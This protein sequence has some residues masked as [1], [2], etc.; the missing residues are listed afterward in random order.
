MK[1]K[2]IGLAIC[3][4]FAFNV[5]QVSAQADLPEAEIIE[6]DTIQKKVEVAFRSVD[7]MD[8]LGGVSVID[9][10]AMTK[11]AYTSSSF[12]FIENLVGGMNGNIWGMNDLLVVV[13]G[14]VRDA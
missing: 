9:V 14:M 11:K 12:A 10:D 5:F 2:F 1:H 3:V 6:T 4:A 13:D 8:L 7:E